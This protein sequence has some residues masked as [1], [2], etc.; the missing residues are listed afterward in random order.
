[1]DEKP[2]KAL[3]LYDG[4]CAFCR[5]SIRWLQWL[6]WL[7]KLDFVNVRKDHPVLDEPGVIAAPLLDQM[8]VWTMKGQLYGGYQAVRWIAW[9]LPLLFP[10]APFLHLPG[11]TQ[12]GDA[13]Y[14][15][16]A[17]N[18]FKLVPCEHGECQLPR[19]EVR[20]GS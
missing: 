18:R 15:W 7:K 5:F 2:K 6:D 3:V 11:I 16:V 12:L 4:D 9:R 17:R 10:L 14:K 1:M 8:H 13:A 20:S 19:K